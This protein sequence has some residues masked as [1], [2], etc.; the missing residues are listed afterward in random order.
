MT[1]E[2]HNCK[3]T[4]LHNAFSL[5]LHK[6]IHNDGSPPTV[7][8]IMHV[9]ST[10]CKLSVPVMPHLLAYDV[11]SIDLAQFMVNFDWKNFITD[12]TSQSAGAGVRASISFAA[13]MLL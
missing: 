7:S 9:L 2:F 3:V 11:R 12:L 10:Y 6:V 13:T 8:V 1:A 5:K 4:I